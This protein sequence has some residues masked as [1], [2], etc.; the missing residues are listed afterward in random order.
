[1]NAAAHGAIDPPRQYG[2]RNRD[3]INRRIEADVR[4]PVERAYLEKI[5]SY[6]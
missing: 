3:H 6:T 2:H 5:S 4:E 1:M